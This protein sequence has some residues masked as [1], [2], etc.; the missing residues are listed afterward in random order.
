MWTG[1]EEALRGWHLGCARG[2]TED[3]GMV[4]PRVPA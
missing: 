1:Q 4:L 3:W 2:L